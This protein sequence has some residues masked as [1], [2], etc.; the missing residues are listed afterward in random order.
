M[1][2]EILLCCIQ[3]SGDVMRVDPKEEE[4]IAH[5]AIIFSV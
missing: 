1:Q 5:V 2:F 4:G 3:T